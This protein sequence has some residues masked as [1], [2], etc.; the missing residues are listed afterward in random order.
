MALTFDD[1]PSIYT[2]RLLDLLKSKGVV[3]TFFL[4]GK[5]WGDAIT[6]PTNVA[7]MQRMLSE[8]HQIGSH[9]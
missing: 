8:G 6:E 9:T 2:G 1:G 5:N 4:N 7:L 3:A